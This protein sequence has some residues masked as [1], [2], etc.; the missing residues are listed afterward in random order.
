[1]LHNEIIKFRNEQKKNELPNIRDEIVRR[2][3]NPQS[4][5]QFKK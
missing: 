2:C 4:Y 1:M 5:F 3:N